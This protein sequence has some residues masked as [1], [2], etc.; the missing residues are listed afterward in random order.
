M[1]K[2]KAPKSKQKPRLFARFVPKMT[3]WGVVRWLLALCIIGLAALTLMALFFA[4]D[5]PSVDNISNTSRNPSVRLLSVSGSMIASFGDVYGDYVRYKDIPLPMIQAVMATEDRRFFEHYGVDPMG[6]LRAA[7]INVRE[8]RVVQ[9]GSTI[10]QQLAKNIFL[11]PERSFKRKF[12]ELI[13]AIW[14]ERKYSKEEILEIYL[15]RMYLG[16]GN[17]GIDAAAR[18]YFGKKAGSLTVQEAAILAGLLK[19]PSRFS[20]ANDPERAAGRGRQV[21]ESMF[22]AGYISKEMVTDIAAK[23]EKRPRGGARGNF[24]FADWVAEQL[25]ELIGTPK[26]DITVVVTLDPRLQKAAE[27]AINGKLE[28]RGKELQV[29]QGALVSIAPDGK[30]LAMVGGR[31]YGESQ[32]NRATQAKRQ[33]GSAFKMFVYLAA[34]MNGFAPNDVLEDKAIDFGEWKP[35]NYDGE[36]TGAI[37][38]RDALAR[39]VNSVAVQLAE[40]AGIQNVVDIAQRMGIKS[41]LDPFL[42]LALGTNE[43]N[44]LELTGAYA[45]LG[46][47]GVTVVP[48]GI[49]E[50]R[51]SKGEVLYEYQPPE[52]EQI[53]PEDALAKINVCLTQV[54]ANGT[55]RK[56]QLNGRYAAAKSGTSQDFRDGWFIGYTPQFTTGVWMGNDNNA[57]TNGVTGGGLPADSFKIFM[58]IAHDGLPV[59]PLPI[60]ERYVPAML[61]AL[62][63]NGVLEQEQQKPRNFWESIFYQGDPNEQPDP[64]QRRFP[65]SR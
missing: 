52:K 63:P 3:L 18:S 55:G 30:I 17:Y 12:Q 60:D 44:L 6:I 56:G 43:V 13:L 31:N 25:P 35:E 45:V 8:G 15:N 47:N 32:Y 33:P 26:E 11:T 53:V 27:D 2:K 5:L 22:E 48:Y 14:L 23:I 51:T 42:S 24:Y 37:L 19:A 40:V 10:T 46:N 54:L 61:P 21:L 59:I 20:P 4:R 50:I 38:L 1:A 58:D 64:L 49:V 16:A 41:Q 28:E 29:T 62:P 36:Y 57:K 65:T 9:G 7:I 39:S 34:F